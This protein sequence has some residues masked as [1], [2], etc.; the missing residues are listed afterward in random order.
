MALADEIV[1]ALTV[2]ISSPQ[3]TDISRMRG[4]GTTPD[5]SR[6]A[7]AASQAAA[8]VESYLGAYRSGDVEAVDFGVRIATVRMAQQWPG[9]T[10]AEGVESY[11][12]LRKELYET[13]QRRV[14]AAS[15]PARVK[16]FVRGLDARYPQ[17]VWGRDEGEE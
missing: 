8:V 7:L 11:R 16:P 4:A 12:D 13:S 5:A 2:A 6:I 14:R 3:L 10:Q 1:S 17:S 15:A 9:Q